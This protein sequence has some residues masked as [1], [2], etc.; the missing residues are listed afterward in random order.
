M[1]L[2]VLSRSVLIVT[3]FLTGL[4]PSFGALAHGV[5]HAH[6]AAHAY[7]AYATEITPDEVGGHEHGHAAGLDRTE[8][9]EEQHSPSRLPEFSA[10]DHQHEHQHTVLDAGLKSRTELASFVVAHAV[11]PP[12]PRTATID[13]R[14][15]VAEIAAPPPERHHTAGSPRAPPAR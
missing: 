9:H 8:D 12:P 13:F 14:K 15:P 1:R 5:A 10:T 11:S 7:G 6:E 3:A 2:S 4:W